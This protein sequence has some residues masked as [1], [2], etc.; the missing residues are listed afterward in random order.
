MESV[1]FK[2]STMVESRVLKVLEILCAIITIIHLIAGAT[3]WKDGLVTMPTEKFVTYLVVTT[4][5][6]IAG[7]I[8]F[9]F[10]SKEEKD[11][12][13]RQKAFRYERSPF[14]SSFK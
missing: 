6:G 12:Y 11:I 4:F 3:V 5:M 10:F 14:R 1:M 2:R 13:E 9:S 8:F 7:M